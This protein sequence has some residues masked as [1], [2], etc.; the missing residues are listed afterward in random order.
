MATEVL[1]PRQGQSVES[2]LIVGWKKQEGDTVAQGEILCE[3][4]TDK[5]TFEVEAPAAGVLLRILHQADDE[6]PVLAPIAYI[7]EAGETVD[8]PSQSESAAG[9]SASGG[10]TAQAEPAAPEPQATSPTEAV[11]PE[12]ALSTAETTTTPEAGERFISP[13]ARRRAEDAGVEWSGLS[14]SGPGGRIIERDVEAALASGAPLTRTAAAQSAGA[15]VPAEGSGIGGRVRVQ[16]LGTAGPDAAASTAGAPGAG[17]G[18]AGSPSAGLPAFPGPVT[19][20]PVRG[21]RKVIAER[22]LNS[23]QTTAQL[24][25]NASADARALQRLR[26]RLKES[27]EALGLRGVTINDLV[28]YAVSRT[29][30]MHEF[31]NAHMQ[32]QKGEAVLTAF[33]HVHLGFAVDTPKGLMV[34]TIRFADRLSVRAMAVEAKRL[35]AACQSGSAGSDDLAPGT[36]TVTNLG[37]LGVE[38]FTPVL[39]PPQVAILGV[40]SIQLKPVQTGSEVEFIPSI[41]LS[42]TIDHRAVDGAPAARFLQALSAAIADVDLLLAL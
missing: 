20:T 11:D 23:L 32:G 14:G 27:N 28:H 16:D 8:T 26:A 6:V 12:K 35:A 30:P 41:G 40:S 3:V 34:P 39:N 42:L 25:L 1:M 17:A 10:P 36:F 31:M 4:E 29:L 18:A 21:V 15:S 7:G 37:G 2:C 5:A 22:M 13:R 38:H 24:T 19:E 33:T 9:D